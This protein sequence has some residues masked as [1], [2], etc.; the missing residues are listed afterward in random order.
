M[1]SAQAARAIGQPFS[2]SGIVAGL[3]R[4]QKESVHPNAQGFDEFFGYIDADHAWEKF[5]TKLWEDRREVSVSG[6]IDDLIT[7]RGV[8]FVRKNSGRPFFVPCVRGHSFSHRGAGGRGRAA[9]GKFVE[10]DADLPLKARYAAM[11]TR[12]DRNIGRLLETIK[13]LDLSRE[14]LIVFTSDH[15][16]TFESGN[17]GTSAALDSNRPFRGQNADL[18]EG[19]RAGAGRGLVAGA[20]SRGCRRG[21]TRSTHRPAADVRGGSRRVG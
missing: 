1:L 21:R 3:E 17:G 16:A 2:A 20:C 15:G 19:R 12:L 18:W 4:E 6:Y 10:D 13:Q 14:T 11:V 9:Q 8:D 5:P 7:D